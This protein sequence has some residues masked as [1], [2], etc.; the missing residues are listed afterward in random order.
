MI[1][2]DI[3]KLNDLYSLEGYAFA[4]IIPQIKEDPSVPKVDLVYEIKKGSKVYFERIDIV[5]NVK[6]R[7]KVIRREFKVAEQGLFDATALRESNENLHRLDYFEEVN[8]STSPG[9]QEDRMNLKVD[10]KEKKTGSFSIGAGYSAVDQFILMGSI[11]QRNLFGRGQSISLDAQLGAIT[12]RYN[13]NF[14]EP[15]LFDTRV[16]ASTNIYNWQRIWDEYTQNS[17]GGSVDFGYPLFEE[18]TR[19]FITYTY[20]DTNVTDI[21]AGAAQVIQDMAGRH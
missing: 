3:L 14:T 1:R 13:L 21:Q 2:K 7:D 8:I 18:F 4:E 9:S 19:G 5:G 10:V 15:W 12:N 6:T 17:L 16:S 20:D 11:T